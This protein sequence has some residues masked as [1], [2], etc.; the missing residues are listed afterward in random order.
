[1]NSNDVMQS[2][3]FGSE[4]PEKVQAAVKKLTP[5]QRKATLNTLSMLK[6]P[7]KIGG[8]VMEKSMGMFGGSIYSPEQEANHAKLQNEINEMKRMKEDRKEIK[9]KI[10]YLRDLKRKESKERR[11]EVIEQLTK[12]EELLK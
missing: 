1:M 8:F 7:L 4:N 6:R 9:T 2:F 11:L 12:A 10:V 3:L 5:E